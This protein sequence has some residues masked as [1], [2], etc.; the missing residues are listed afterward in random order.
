MMRLDQLLVKRSLAAS[1]TQSQKMIQAGQ[2]SVRI[3]G[4]WPCIKKPSHKFDEE[5]ELRVELGEEQKYVSRGGL[6]LEGALNRDE[7]KK[8]EGLSSAK[9]A[10]DV[11]QSTG[12]FTDCLLQYGVAQVVGVDVGRDQLCASLRDDPRVTCLEKVN[13]RAL[14]AATLQS[15]AGVSSFDLIVMDVS[16]ISQSLILP[17]LV[18]L[19][20]EG[21]TLLSLVK[22]QFE[23]GVGGVGKGGVVKKPELYGQVETRLCKEIL[24]L[25]L[26]LVDYFES[27]IN[28]GDGN[29]EFFLCAQKPT[30]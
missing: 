6:K 27:P 17:S 26:R 5:V 15:C 10:L 11:G 24:G 22:P 29:R 18:P 16:F 28:G 25:N 13:A 4:Q 19:L 9:I 14:T 12:G 21:G 2:V 20:A 3:A 23:V 30:A 8:L 7:L 1:R